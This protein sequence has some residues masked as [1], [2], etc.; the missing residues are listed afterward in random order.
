MKTLLI[1]G[2]I[3]NEGESR[4]GSVLIEGDI[5]SAVVYEEDFKY[6]SEYQAY[7]N[8]L[9]QSADI[10]DVTGMHIFPG[11]I[12]DHV[13]FREP[14]NGASGTIGSESAAAVI[15]GVT[16]FMDMP[17]NAPAAVTLK[18]LEKKFDR[19]KET[20]YANYSFYLG[21]SNDNLQEIRNIDP[22]KICG[23]KVFMGSST[24]NL[25]VDREEALRNVF[26]Y[27]PVLVAAHCEDNGIIAENMR[28][29]VAKYG[30]DIPTEAHPEI[31][32]GRACINSTN[33]AIALASE[34]ETRLHILH[35]STASEARILKELQTNAHLKGESAK[36]TGEA[37][38]HYLW[39]S[40]KDYIRYKNLIKCNPAIKDE[41]DMLAVREAVS[42]GVIRIIG[43]DHAPHP[44]ANKLKPYSEAPGGIPLVQYSLQMM[45]ELS[46]SGVFTLEQVAEGMSHAPAEL[47]DISKRGYI[48]EG[49]Y[50]DLVIVNLNKPD[51]YA[52]NHPASKCGWSPFSE[53]GP[54]NFSSTIVATYVNGSKVAENG[55]LTGVR[56]P[57]RLEFTRSKS[58]K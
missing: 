44:L 32:S 16:S 36:I 2:T 7:V 21:A 18:L 11:V 15:G 29:A 43:T 42:Q 25:L 8:R 19:A 14:G 13:H 58:G 35:I 17:N 4:K 31:R 28:C 39:F 12:D 52:A 57:M 49:Y 33:K 48:R 6:F 23:V 41:K 47:F 9:S 53:V 45:L 3:V 10:Q 1:N 54:K 34:Y 37:C 56:N 50:A 26:R 30:N 24:G 40:S 46:K 22:N 51:T 38:V 27:S 20:S 5:I 55:R